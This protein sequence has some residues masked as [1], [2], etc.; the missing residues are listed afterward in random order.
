MSVLNSLR[1]LQRAFAAAV[2]VREPARFASRIRSVGL[3]APE[4]MQIYC[5]N[6]FLGFEQA[7]ADVFAAIQRL[8]GE[9]F[10]R[11]AARRFVRERPSR[12]GNLHDFGR[13]FAAW[14]R[15][16]AEH[17]ELPYLGDV[18]NLEWM[19]HESCHAGD[20]PP[21]DLSALAAIPETRHAALRFRLHPAARLVASR[22]P[23][24]A[25]WEANRPGAPEGREIQLD[26]GPD[27]L[28]VTR[29]GL[30]VVNVRLQPGEF[31]LLA[32]LAVGARIEQACDAAAA[33]QSDF[34]P[35]RAMARLVA[36][37]VLAGIH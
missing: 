31:A 8:V 26:D 35:G 9:Q 17:A 18:A 24:L 37:R 1:E 12:S 29:V 7:L 19:R 3:P 2:V 4:R 15:G 21:L 13:E 36:S 10:F 11:Q 27:Y 25:I 20:A 6:V 30:R 5:N 22:F 28:L 14:L 33:A 16:L 23:V 32:E 34:D